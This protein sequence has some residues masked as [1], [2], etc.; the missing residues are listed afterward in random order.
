MSDKD[1]D[2]EYRSIINS[3]IDLANKHSE[4][5][6][7]E[8]VSM[9]LLFAASRFN[10]FIVASHAS[11]IKKYEAD[12][13]KAFE[14]FT[15]EYHKMLNENLDDYKKFFDENMKYAHLINTRPS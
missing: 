12:R 14:F 15:R 6:N 11:D 7:R 5:A 9:A 2:Q 3:F 4:S 1:I 13:N 10:S 8:N